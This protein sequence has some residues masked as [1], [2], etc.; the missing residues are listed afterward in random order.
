M[1][2]FVE[3]LNTLNIGQLAVIIA[4]MWFFYNRLDTKIEK[5]EE[6]LEAKIN[7]VEEKLEAKINNLYNLMFTCLNVSADLQAPKKRKRGA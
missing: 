4:A 2:N 1:E 3:I 5:V 6:K 7:R